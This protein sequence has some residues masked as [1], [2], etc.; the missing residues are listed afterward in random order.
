MTTS[1]SAYQ[2]RLE[3]SV[4]EVPSAKLFPNSSTSERHKRTLRSAYRKRVALSARRTFFGIK[5]NYILDKRYLLCPVFASSVKEYDL[6][7][8]VFWPS[9]RRK[10]DTDGALS[11]LKG[12]LDGVADVLGVDDRKLDEL[13]IRQRH[14]AGDVGSVELHFTFYTDDLSHAHCDG[15]CIDNALLDNT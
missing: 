3:I 10:P 6:D 2:R 7:I 13:T 1:I 14:D 11:S 4:P 9:K 5:P 8:T 12:L 15:A